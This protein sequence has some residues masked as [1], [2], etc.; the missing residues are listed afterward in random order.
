MENE[1][2]F[3]VNIGQV[4]PDGRIVITCKTYLGQFIRGAVNQNT[5]ITF[6]ADI[7]DPEITDTSAA[8]RVIEKASKP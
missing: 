1:P 3:V 8:Q 4:L 7:I 6:R 2:A 5:T